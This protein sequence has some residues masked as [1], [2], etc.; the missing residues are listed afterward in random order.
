[1]F[2]LDHRRIRSAIVADF[3]PGPECGSFWPG[4][5]SVRQARQAETVLA[6]LISLILRGSHSI[7]KGKRIDFGPQQSV[8]SITAAIARCRDGLERTGM[9][10]KPNY[11]FERSERAKSKAAK[12]AERLR[13]KAEKS[14]ARKA[15]AA[16]GQDE[17][18]NEDDQA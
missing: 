4:A 13:A 9:P 15:E 3:G 6:R 5:L 11:Q 8:N 18:Q 2:P 14:E 16:E 17:D 12:K 10:R 7:W 1:M